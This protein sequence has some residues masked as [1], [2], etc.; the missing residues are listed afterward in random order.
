[1][2][3]QLAERDRELKSLR[4]KQLDVERENSDLQR[5]LAATK[6]ALDELQKDSLVL[7]SE[8]KKDQKEKKGV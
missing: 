7:K 2:L 1:L 4:T 6:N 8:C 3:T 5:T